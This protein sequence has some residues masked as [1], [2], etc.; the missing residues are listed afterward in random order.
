MRPSRAGICFCH[1]PAMPQAAAA[2]KAAQQDGLVP[3]GRRHVG[4]SRASHRGVGGNTRFRRRILRPARIEQGREA[5][6]GALAVHGFRQP[7]AGTGRS[8]KKQSR[9]PPWRRYSVQHSCLFPREIPRLFRADRQR[10]S[11][12][13]VFAEV[14]LGGSTE[15]GRPPGG[16]RLGTLAGIG[17]IPYLKKI[18][19]I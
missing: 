1:V 13:Y 5:E 16:S 18:V 19:C 7:A 2:R 17:K 4:Q 10:K 12:S 14:T 15:A 11:L 3:D 9:A 8:N 6:S